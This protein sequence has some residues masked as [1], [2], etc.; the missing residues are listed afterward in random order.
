MVSL[1][2]S[3]IVQGSLRLSNLNNLSVMEHI[4]IVKFLLVAQLLLSNSSVSLSQFCDVG[5]PG[6]DKTDAKTIKFLLMVPYADP[7]N[8]SS[9][10]FYYD[11]QGHQMTPIAYLAVKHINN[12]TDILKDYTLDFIMSDTGCSAQR[13]V[14]SFAKDIAHRDGPLAGIVG[15]SCDS[16]ATSIIQLTTKERLPLVSIHWG[17]FAHFADSTNAFG[18]IGSLSTV[19]DAYFELIKKNNWKRIALLYRDADYGLQVLFE[20]RKKFSNLSGFE[21]ASSCITDI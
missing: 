10:T 13:E 19:A 1:Q 4:I 18:I 8:R 17:R 21:I 5:Q 7:L 12:R 20:L 11:F 2:H 16:S 15:P 3:S 6:Q 14:Y 9:F